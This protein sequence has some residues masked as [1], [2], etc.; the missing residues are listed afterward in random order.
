MQNNA[1][2]RSYRPSDSC[3]GSRIDGV[4]YQL[5]DITDRDAVRGLMQGVIQR[6]GRID[7]T[8]NNAAVNRARLLVDF[9]ARHP[10]MS[11]AMKILNLWFR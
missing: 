2:G 6:Y 11:L 5:C 8:V 3:T 4:D 10:G 7:G 1:G 9:T